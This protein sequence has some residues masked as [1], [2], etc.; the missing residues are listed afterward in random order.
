MRAL[1]ADFGLSVDMAATAR[2]SDNGIY[3][4]T[5]ETKVPIRWASI[6]VGLF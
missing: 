2:G 4:G 5:Q 1:V 3:G 6:E